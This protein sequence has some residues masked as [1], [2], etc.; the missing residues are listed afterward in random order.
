MSKDFMKE[1]KD[2][3]KEREEGANQTNPSP[4]PPPSPEQTYQ[5]FVRFDD[6][7]WISFTTNSIQM[8]N[9]M[10]RIFEGLKG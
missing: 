5:H 1:L 3:L 10:K 2:T 7:E 4:S 6:G 8:Y 9:N